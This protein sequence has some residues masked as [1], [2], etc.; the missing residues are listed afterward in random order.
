MKLSKEDGRLLW[1]VQLGPAPSASM[2]RDMDVSYMSHVDNLLYVAGESQASLFLST[3]KG[4][5]RDVIVARLDTNGKT[6][7]GSQYGIENVDFSVRGLLSDADGVYVIGE[8]TAVSGTAGGGSARVGGVQEGSHGRVDSFL[9]ALHP[10]SGQVMWGLQHGVREGFMDE[11]HVQEVSFVSSRTQDGAHTHS[12]AVS[13]YSYGTNEGLIHSKCFRHTYSL[14]PGSDK[15]RLLRE[16]KDVRC[17]HAT[18]KSRHEV[19]QHGVASYRTASSHP[20][21]SSNP[22]SGKEVGIVVT[23]NTCQPG[24]KW[25]QNKSDSPYDSSTALVWD[26]SKHRQHPRPVCLPCPAGEFSDAPFSTSCRG[27][28]WGQHSGEGAAEC[29]FC[30]PGSVARPHGRPGGGCEAC[31]GVKWALTGRKCDMVHLVFRRVQHGPV[32]ALAGIACALVGTVLVMRHGLQVQL[33]TPPGLLMALAS[34]HALA[35]WAFLLTAMFFKPLLCILT[36]IVLVL[37]FVHFLYKVLKDCHLRGSFVHRPLHA[38]FPFAAHCHGDAGPALAAV[39]RVVA[40]CVYTVYYSALYLVG[41]CL[42]QSKLY[43]DVRVQSAWQQVVFGVGI[44]GN[45]DGSEEEGGPDEQSMHTADA[46]SV[47]TAQQ[48]PSRSTSTIDIRFFNEATLLEVMGVAVPL[49]VVQA[50]NSMG[51]RYMPALGPV[52][53][54]CLLMNILVV[55]VHG[56]RVVRF[57]FLEGFGVLEVPLWSAEEEHWRHEEGEGGQQQQQQDEEM[58]LLRSQVEQHSQQTDSLQERVAS[59]HEANVSLAGAYEEALAR[60]SALEQRLADKKS[61]DKEESAR[62]GWLSALW[63]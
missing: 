21:F 19:S 41:Y 59:Q 1:G 49:L 63:S 22:R 39:Y 34:L 58:S 36:S 17:D 31:P 9:L 57:H 33:M 23:K 45:G 43:A 55:L 18:S 47:D 37:P 6:T 60:I 26:S 48:H 27:C 25:Q 7:W 32:M 35:N 46:I 16:E 2:Y 14:S 15:S 38:N 62:S 12:I 10:S 53:L 29:R 51:R 40:C 44:G 56:Y 3:K 54:L 8:V 50:F 24:T 13:G 52:E 28:G 11:E 5:A 4:N 61:D 42:Y 30:P 20:L